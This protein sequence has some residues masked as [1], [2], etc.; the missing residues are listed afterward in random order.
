MLR[1][2]I[3]TCIGCGVCALRCEFDA[4]QICYRE[5]QAQKVSTDFDQLHATIRMENKQG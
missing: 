2:D 5:D 1:I 3:E 4:L